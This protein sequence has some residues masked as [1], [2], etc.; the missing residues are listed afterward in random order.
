MI[1]GLI[2]ERR[3]HRQAPMSVPHDSPPAPPQT[4]QCLPGPASRHTILSVAQGGMGFPKQTHSW[5]PKSRV[6]CTVLQDYHLHGMCLQGPQELRN[7][8]MELCFPAALHG[9]LMC[10]PSI[11]NGYLPGRAVLLVNLQHGC[12][13]LAQAL[14]GLFFSIAA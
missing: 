14:G 6:T 10:D 12:A 5:R 4:P 8:S 11:A 2:Y 13:A 7:H 9:P 3:E 1:P